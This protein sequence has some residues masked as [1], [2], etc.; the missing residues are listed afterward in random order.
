[1]GGKIAPAGDVDLYAVEVTKAGLLKVWVDEPGDGSCK[2]G[3]LGVVPEGVLDSEVRLLRQDGTLVAIND[4]GEGEGF[5]SRVEAKV[6]VGSYLVQ[7][8]AS[9]SSPSQVFSYLLKV[10]FP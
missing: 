2:R 8:K 3:E 1:M 9:P 4:N 6:A 7:V 5:C 10:E